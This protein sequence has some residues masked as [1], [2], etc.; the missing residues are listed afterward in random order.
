[1]VAR[2]EKTANGYVIAVTPEMVRLW[3]LREGSEIELK[4][5]GGSSEARFA[6]VD[7]ALAAFERTLPFHEQTYRDLAK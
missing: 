7:E 4:P 3:D 1:M 2:V 6:T 5:V